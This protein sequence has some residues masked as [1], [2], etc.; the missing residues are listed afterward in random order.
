[1]ANP[2][3]NVLSNLEAEQKVL[4]RLEVELFDPER[5]EWAGVDGFRYDS[6]IIRDKMDSEKRIAQFESILMRHGW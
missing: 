5:K 2:M 4:N 6:E 3:D 1:M